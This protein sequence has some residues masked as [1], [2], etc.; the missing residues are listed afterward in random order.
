MIER[1]TLAEIRAA[2]AERLPGALPRRRLCWRYTLL[3]R[4]PAR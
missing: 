2:A 3:W 1:D 4:R